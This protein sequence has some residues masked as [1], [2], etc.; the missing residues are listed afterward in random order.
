MESVRFPGKPLAPLNGVPMIVYCAKNV[1]NAGQSVRVCTDSEAI[2]SVCKLY[3]IPHILTP[4]FNTGTDRVAWAAQQYESDIVVNLQG[5]EPL[6]TSNDIEAFVDHL[7]RSLPADDSNDLI[8][9]AVSPLDS[10]NAFDPNNVKC[11]ISHN[12]QILYLSRKAIPNSPEPDSYYKQLGLYGMSFNTLLSFSTMRQTQLELAEKIEM[13]R[14]LDNS[15]LLTSFVI[16]HPT[17][18]VDTPEDF[19][20]AIALLE[21]S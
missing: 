19:V 18:S 17:V 6:I 14:W 21:S 8:V 11:S 16:D 10:L 15:R 12:N 9:N 3:D 1:I 20:K 2:C 5:D 13:I 7:V 4:S